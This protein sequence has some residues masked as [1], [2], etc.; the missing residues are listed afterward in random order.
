MKLNSSYQLIKHKLNFKKNDGKT[1]VQWNWVDLKRWV[2]SRLLNQLIFTTKNADFQGFFLLKFPHCLN[3]G[4]IKKYRV[5][6]KILTVFH[7]FQK[8]IF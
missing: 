3:V 2:A 1:D 7:N 4:G 6:F 5:F 8:L